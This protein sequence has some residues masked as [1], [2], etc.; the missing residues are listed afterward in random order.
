MCVWVCLYVLFCVCLTGK[1]VCVCVSFLAGVCLCV[2]IE[3]FF[4]ACWVDVMQLLLL[5]RLDVLVLLHPAGVLQIAPV[6]SKSHQ[7]MDLRGKRKIPTKWKYMWSKSDYN[8]VLVHS[9]T[10]VPGHFI[11]YTLIQSN[12]TQQCLVG[13]TGKYSNIVWKGCI[14]C[15]IP[16]SVRC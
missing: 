13:F 12:T 8:P 7:E 11:R 16:I 3:A 6:S 2:G 15:V 4:G 5:L 9:V 10:M 14:Y 1:C